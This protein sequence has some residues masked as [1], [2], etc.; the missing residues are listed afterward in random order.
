MKYYAGVGARKT[1]PDVLADM[2]KLATLLEDK[3]F[4]L[5]SGGAV[6]ADTAFESGVNENKE[7]YLAIH[8]TPEAMEIAKKYHPAWFAC[9]YYVRKLLGRNTFQVLGADLKTPSQFLVCWT[10]DGCTSHATRTRETGGT[11]TAISIADDLGIPIY[12]LELSTIQNIIDK[13]TL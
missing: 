3:G 6:G 2:E 5:R 1:P 8:A 7:I 9:S 12:N 10:P 11:G 13:E 4:C